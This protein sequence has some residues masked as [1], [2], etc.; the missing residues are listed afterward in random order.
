MIDLTARYR[1]SP[2]THAG[3]RWAVHHSAPPAP[4]SV[5]GLTQQQE[6]AVLDSLDRYHRD[7]QKYTVGIGYH[8]CVFPSGR[9]YRVGRQ[10]TQ[11]AHI[12]NR[13][14]EYDGLCFMGSF[15]TTR[16]SDLALDEGLRVIRASGM[17]VGGR[18][19][20]L[21]TPGYT[22]CPGSWPL[23]LLT[24]RMLPEDLS[25][26]LT[27]TQK[28]VLSMLNFPV[29]LGGLGGTVT[30]TSLPREGGDDIYKIRVRR[31]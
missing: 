29:S 12:L 27:G 21:A 15:T 6:I 14:H 20:D 4:V 28:T 19:R 1:Q 11:R 18:H 8:V 9:S 2:L 30:A 23:A 16:P 10:G 24:G 17:S 5:V 22:E 7:V 13:N 26:P 31:T 3:K 25:P